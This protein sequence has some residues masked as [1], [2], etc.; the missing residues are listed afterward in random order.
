MYPG[1]IVETA[2]QVTLHGKHFDQRMT[3]R[4]GDVDVSGQLHFKLLLNMAFQFSLNTAFQLLLPNIHVMTTQ[5][6]QCCA[7]CL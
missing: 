5:G 3:V 2:A 6:R 4:V 1:A 7:R